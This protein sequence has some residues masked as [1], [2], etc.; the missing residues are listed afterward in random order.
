M[1]NIDQQIELQEAGMAGSTTFMTEA[2]LNISTA[3]AAQPQTAAENQ[4][5]VLNSNDKSVA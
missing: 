4:I 5:Q 3:Q 2:K 1:A